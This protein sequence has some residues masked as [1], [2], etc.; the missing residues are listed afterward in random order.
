ML[1]SF[2]ARES[3][4]AI[5]AQWR[6]RPKRPLRISVLKETKRSDRRIANNPH[7]LQSVTLC[8]EAGWLPLETV[9]GQEGIDTAWVPTAAQTLR[10]PN[11]WCSLGV[12]YSHSPSEQEGGK[13]EV[14]IRLP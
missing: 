7:P 1:P 13:I 5:S 3:Q 11:G 12:A 8:Q 10:A 4:G 2:L 9:S 6:V 14:R